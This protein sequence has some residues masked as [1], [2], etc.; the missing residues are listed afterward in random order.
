[1]KSRL[2]LVPNTE[3]EATETVLQLSA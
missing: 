1:A 3:S 2:T